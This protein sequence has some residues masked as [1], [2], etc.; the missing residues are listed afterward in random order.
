[1][2]PH[3][4]HRYADSFSLRELVVEVGQSLA[5]RIAAR[6][7]DSVLDIPSDQVITADR[8][9]IRRAV[10]NLMLNA[11]DAMPEGGSLVVTSVGGPHALELEVA[12]TGPTLSDEE[13]LR[14]FAPST[15]NQRGATGWTLA[16]VRRIAEIHGGSVTV[17]NCPEG[18]AAFTLRIPG[19]VTL[20]AAA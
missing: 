9:L 7:I 11:I 1:M 14:A 19:S 15:T 6:A 10:Q 17:A 16:G 8:E 3:P 18:G 12:D 13:R 20:E 5:S 2:L 4:N